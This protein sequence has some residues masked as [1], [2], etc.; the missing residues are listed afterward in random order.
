MS[1]PCSFFKVA[2][3]DAARIV[4]LLSLNSS[5]V[6]TPIEQKT[7]IQ[8]WKDKAV[9]F[10]RFFHMVFI[11]GFTPVVFDMM[12]YPL[13]QLLTFGIYI[14]R[15][16]VLPIAMQ[17]SGMVKYASWDKPAIGSALPLA[18]DAEAV[19]NSVKSLSAESRLAQQSFGD[20][21]YERMLMIL[22]R[23]TTHLSPHSQSP[24]HPFISGFP[25]NFMDHLTGVYKVLFGRSHRTVPLISFPVLCCMVVT[26][27]HQPQFVVRA[28]L[29]H[30]VYGTYGKQCSV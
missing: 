19:C 11:K 21:D 5:H 4:S 1:A 3:Q 9:F 25:G 2:C 23:K 13:W 22:H 7:F 29:Y 18:T 26:A 8:K 28:G 6:T 12:P 15:L 30:S 14:F 17:L 24:G 16:V 10:G 27:W 20:A